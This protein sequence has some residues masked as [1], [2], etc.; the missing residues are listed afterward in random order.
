MNIDIV[1]IFVILFVILIL[2]NILKNSTKESMQ[3]VKPS[4]NFVLYYADWCGHSRN[5][6][7][8]W[9]KIKIASHKNVKCMEYECDKNKKIC[10]QNNITGYPA[11]I[12]HKVDGSSI[13]YPDDQP[14]TK[15]KVLEFIAKNS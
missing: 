6:L 12:L 2:S 15:D 13:K 3:S 9:Q 8:E 10:Q 1:I 4:N 14:R 11:M 5:F 7:S